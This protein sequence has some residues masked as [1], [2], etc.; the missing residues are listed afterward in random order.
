MIFLERTEH[1]TKV[2]SEK[3]ALGVPRGEPYRDKTKLLSANLLKNDILRTLGPPRNII[4]APGCIIRTK[5]EYKDIWNY[6][7]GDREV[8]LLSSKTKFLLMSIYFDEDGKVL[9]YTIVEHEG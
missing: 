9:D 7:R 4:S 2:I 1:K 8:I 6:I 3:I 5:A